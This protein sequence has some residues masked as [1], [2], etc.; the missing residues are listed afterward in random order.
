MANCSASNLGDVLN[1]NNANWELS[2]VSRIK[3]DTD[4]FCKDLPKKNYFMLPERRSLES[5]S[6][7]CDKLGGSVSIPL[8]ES[9]NELITQ[10]GYEFYDECEAKSQSG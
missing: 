5:G 6:S 7:I 8:Q 4:E 1:W 3:L 2:N 9:E 10:I